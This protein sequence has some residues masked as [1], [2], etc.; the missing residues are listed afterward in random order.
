[1]CLADSS[2]SVFPPF[3]PSVTTC[4]NRSLSSS[5][6]PQSIFSVS[7]LLLPSR[8]V[9]V[10]S[11]CQSLFCNLVVQLLGQLFLGI[12]FLLTLSFLMD[13]TLTLRC[14]N[15]FYFPCSDATSV[16][17]NPRVRSAFIVLSHRFF[18]TGFMFIHLFK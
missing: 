18:L 4:V 11:I 17:N 7:G 13:L 12:A 8:C 10:K 3:Y 2:P 14:S 6:L 1:M 5:L 16:Y 15:M 9:S